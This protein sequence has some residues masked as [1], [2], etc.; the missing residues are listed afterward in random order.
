VSAPKAGASPTRAASFRF[1]FRG[2][3]TLFAAEPNARLHLLATLG[4]ILLGAALRLTVLEW[5]A[6]VGAIALVWTAEALNTAVE[7][8]CDLV[9]PEPHPLV[10]RAK[11]VAAAGVLFAAIG[12]ALVGALVF[13]ERLLR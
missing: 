7:T 12:A 10:A 2:L 6:V 13:G 8:I 5:C 4:A 3:R 1:A 9:H 11:D